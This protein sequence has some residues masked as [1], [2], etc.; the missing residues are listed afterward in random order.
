MSAASGYLI[1]VVTLDLVTTGTS[2]GEGVTA[3]DVSAV[4]Y[5]IFGMAFGVATSIAAG[6]Y[7]AWRASQMDPI[8]AIQ[9]R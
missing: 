3:F 7:P 8:D 9:K 2:F 4:G 1:S 6:F 5:I